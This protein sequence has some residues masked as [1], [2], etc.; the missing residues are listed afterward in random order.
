MSSMRVKKGVNW[1]F[2]VVG[3][4]APSL[5]WIVGLSR[6]FGFLLGSAD[7]GLI[8]TGGYKLD[9]VIVSLDRWDRSF[10]EIDIGLVGRP[11]CGGGGYRCLKLWRYR[12]SYRYQHVNWLVSPDH[13][14]TSQGNLTQGQSNII[15]F[16]Q[17]RIS[18][19]YY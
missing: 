19:S 7:G 15:L 2:E 11:H 4:S 10:R 12:S 5:E 3:S 14:R 6:L 16:S 18:T 8:G 13:R 17:T 9:L 1:R